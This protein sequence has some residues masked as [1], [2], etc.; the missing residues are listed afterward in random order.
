LINRPSLVLGA[1]AFEPALV[2]VGFYGFDQEL[3]AWL[4]EFQRNGGPL[5]SIFQVRVV[6]SEAALDDD[7][8]AVSG[9]Y[10]VVEDGIRFTPHLPFELG[11]S[12]RASFDARPPG[13]HAEVLTDEFSLPRER[14]AAAAEV[15]NIYPSGDELPENLLRF[16]IVFS[17]SMQ[18]GRAE[19][20]ISVLGP[21]GEPAR[22]VLYRAPIELWDRSCD[23]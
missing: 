11:L 15:K 8:P 12:Y 14:S 6:Q 10:D 17:N 3:M 9:R 4:G 5:Q 7:L 2:N 13:Y 18:R 22:D 1:D 16:Y 23:A 20:E 19:A 21:D